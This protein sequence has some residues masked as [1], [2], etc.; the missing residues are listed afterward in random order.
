MTSRERQGPAL[1]IVQ[2]RDISVAEQRA[3]SHLWQKLISR[4]GVGRMYTVSYYL[5]YA[6]A[7][8]LTVSIVMA[9][10]LLDTVAPTLALQ[11]IVASLGFA[12]FLVGTQ[13]IGTRLAWDRYWGVLRT[14]NRY[15]LEAEGL[16]W[17]TGR[18]LYSCGL[19]K[20]E[21]I[22]NDEQRLIAVLPHDGGVVVVKTAFEGQD[23]ERFA[24]ELVRR[25]HEHRGRIGAI[26]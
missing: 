15:T 3:L 23:V 10:R 18:G 14:G 5:S 1:E 12:I 2:M 22:L 11:L 25:W 19:D 9:A 21:T 13:W 7:A 26:A 17:S 24:A 20:I 6:F 8:F 4:H 16:R